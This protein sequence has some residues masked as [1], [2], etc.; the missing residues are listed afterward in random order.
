MDPTATQKL[1]YLVKISQ[2]AQLPFGPIFINASFLKPRSKH[3]EA[4]CYSKNDELKTQDIHSKKKHEAD[5]IG[6]MIAQG[7]AK[8]SS[9]YFSL[10]SQKKVLPWRKTTWIDGEFFLKLL[11]PSWLG[12]YGRH[13]LVSDNNCNLNGGVKKGLHPFLGICIFA[14]DVPGY[15]PNFD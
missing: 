8:R 13:K 4:V 3:I 15:R 7:N 5:Q 11:D 1:I 10:H 14:I 6:C 9:L 12:G 2:Q